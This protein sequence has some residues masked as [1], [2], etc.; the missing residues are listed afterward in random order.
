M[1]SMQLRGLGAAT[2]SLLL[3]LG[4]LGFQY[5]GDM[6]PCPLCIWQRWPHVIAVVAGL[7]LMLWSSRVFPLTGMLATLFC[8]GVALY[9]TG[10]E[11]GWW[12]G[13]DSCTMSDTGDVSAA[14]LTK[15]LLETPVVLC[16][17][18]PWAML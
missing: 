18:V 15:Q 14:E 17:Q 2:G 7:G 1:N 6:P 12:A 5:L 16:D 10:I 8:A 4:A 13:P 11:R 3:L 9:H